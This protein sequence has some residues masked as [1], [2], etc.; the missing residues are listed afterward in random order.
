MRLAVVSD[1]AVGNQLVAAV[2][3]LAPSYVAADDNADYSAN[4]AGDD[5]SGNRAADGAGC[6][7][8]RCAGHDRHQRQD[9]SRQRQNQYLAHGFFLPFGG[10]GGSYPE[11]VGARWLHGYDA[12]NDAALGGDAAGGT[13]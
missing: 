11:H 2:M 4:R 1:V 12:Y 7:A 8:A 6:R 13:R 3:I 5:S 10:Y 9:R